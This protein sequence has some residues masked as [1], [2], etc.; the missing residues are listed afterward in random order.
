[1]DINGVIT[2]VA[3]NGQSGYSGDGGPATQAGLYRPSGVAIDS[4]GNI[5]IVDFYNDRIRKISLPSIFAGST[6]AGDIAFAEENGLGY[7]LDSTGLHK[8]TIDLE[9]G[10]TLMTFGYQNK[11]LISITDRFS[12]QTMIQRDGSGIP[13]SIISPDGIVTTLTID[14]SNHLTKATYPDNTSYSFTYTSD[15]LMTDEYDPKN[16][17][18]VHQYDTNGRITNIF[19][20]EGGTWSYP[21]TVDNA[22]NILVSVLTAEGNL[23]TYKDKTDSTGAYTSIKTDPTG[24][25]TT[26]TSSTDGLTETEQFCSMSQTLKYDLDSEY[27]F[28]YIKEST[29]TS[30]AGLSL[31]TTF[32]KTYQDTNADKKPDLIT[33]T[34]AINSK[35]WTAINNV[36][37]GTVANTSPLGRIVTRKYDTTNLLTNEITVAGLSPITFSYDTR[38]RL[39]STTTGSRTTTIAYDANG[40]IDYM[41][42]PDNKTFDYTYDI[43]GRL[44]NEHRPDGT[45]VSYD[46][47]N[48]GNMTVLTNPKS[49]SNTFGY[50]ANDQRKTWTTPMS[51]SYLYSYD[52]ERK[53][54]TITFPSGKLI[55]NTYTKGLLTST[56]T[57]EGITSY[58]YGCSDSLT[59]AVKGT[60]KISF[61]YD[62]T[63]LKT[64]TR[65]GLLNQTIGYAYNNDF[66]LSS[67]TYAGAT[68]TLAYDNDGLLTNA[69]AFTITRNAQNGLPLS[70]SDGVITNART[71]SGYGELDSNAYSIGGVNRYSYNLTRDLSG[72]ITQRVENVGG[73]T[74]T[75]D[76]GYDSLGRLIEVK[77]NN[78]VVENYTYDA[79]GNRLTDNSRSYSYSNEDH[80]ITAGNVTYQFNVDGFLTSKTTTTGMTTY[81]YSSRGELLSATLPTG[82]VISYDY[83]PMGRRITKRI[84][85]VIVEK[86][87]WRDAITLLAVYNGNNN[88]IS[89]FNYADGRL[90]ASMT[91]AGATYYLS[92]DQV[93]SLRVVS[94]STGNIIKK[95]DYDSFGNIIADTNSGF[96]VPFGFAGGLHD[97][98]TGLVRFGARDYDP[99]IG[100][101][102]AKDPIDFA[103]GDVNLFG[104]V[105]N[106]PVNFVDPDG[107]NPI[108]NFLLRNA[109]KIIPLADKA[110]NVLKN[111]PGPPKVGE[112]IKNAEKLWDEYQEAVDRNRGY[113]GEKR[114]V[115]GCHPGK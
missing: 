1:M 51:G 19:D 49:I 105:G 31:T 6:V 102:T 53:L 103:G 94:D 73:E 65:T 15:G 2:T 41:T 79:N 114:A 71:F 7:I 67:M 77:K 50:T 35:N 39:T 21:R 90:P 20:P 72:R 40:N 93:G 37:T 29:K 98:D 80:L 3:G 56:H 30:P 89:R 99:S 5:Y 62:G 48:N 13:T 95:V 14:A 97:R 55:T 107:L 104:Y 87:L 112:T 109:D 82:T 33:E 45:V 32:A 85:G 66:R 36:L 47:D 61:T 83:D 28:K 60:E 101:W 57:S 58:S 23:T 68:Q 22:G 10:K 38:G 27:K 115:Q 110:F 78:V 26:V 24:A 18:F 9:T 74:I 70:V 54:K 106:N 12:N 52:K 91:Y 4:A 75:W 76:Y 113:P 44:K 111:P 81:N 84:N 16:N 108:I 17:H 69:G 46:Y 86:Y 100:R 92:Y 42:T 63:L 88:L 25:T 11:Q 43:M 34:T 64:D 96:T 59:E 8:S